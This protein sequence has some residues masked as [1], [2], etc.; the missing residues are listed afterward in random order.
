MRRAASSRRRHLAIWFP[1]LPT[2]RLRREQADPAPPEHPVVLVD[3]D[4]GALRLTAANPAA[5]S[6]GLTPGMTLADAQARVPGIEA[7]PHDGEADARLLH[8]VL[9]DFDR[10]TPMAALDAPHGLML[11]VTGC[12]HLFGGEARM[13][14]VVRARA[15]RLGLQ[16]RLALGTPPD[17]L[18]HPRLAAEQVGAAGHVQH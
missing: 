8:A 10:F 15:E 6:L 11:D 7:I 4:R 18:H 16:V 2:D 14:D 12:A 13:V 1:F 9:E 3:K 5:L 17:R